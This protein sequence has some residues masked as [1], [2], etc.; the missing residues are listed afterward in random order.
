[1]KMD[2]FEFYKLYKAMRLHFSTDKYNIVETR[3]AVKVPKESFLKRHDLYFINKLANKFD[4]SEAIE[5]LLSNFITG[6]LSGGIFSNEAIDNYT[7]WKGRKIRL[8]YEFRSDLARMN[9]EAAKKNIDDFLN[10]SH[11]HPFVIKM[12][13]SKVISIETLVIINK[14]EPFIELLDKHLADDM[15]WPEV[16][17]L[18]V[19]YSPFVRIKND[20]EKYEAI[21]RAAR[22]DYE[23]LRDGTSL[24]QE[25]CGAPAEFYTGDSTTSSRYAETSNNNGSKSTGSSETTGV[26]AIFG[27]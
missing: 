10:C 24:H 22:E 4:R 3:G 26:L 13:L 15:V 5:F 8:Q 16:K 27:S 14:L 7:I 6:D 20:R 25:G 21:F 1:M 17:R 23:G 19:K 11:G 9:Q 2:G 18:L 12:Y